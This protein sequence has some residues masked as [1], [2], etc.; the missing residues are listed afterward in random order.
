MLSWTI[1]LLWA[2]YCTT[3]SCT[4][5]KLMVAKKNLHLLGYN[6][7]SCMPPLKFKLDTKYFIWEEFENFVAGLWDDEFD[8]SGALFIPKQKSVQGMP[9]SLVE[10]GFSFTSLDRNSI[11]ALLTSFR[12]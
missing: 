7:V 4:D 12:K 5:A 6:P 11:L 3:A 1:Y 2:A 10:F 9:L 8:R